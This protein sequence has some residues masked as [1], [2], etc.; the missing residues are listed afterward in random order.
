[1]S[2][3][4]PEFD[5]SDW[6]DP[7]WIVMLPGLSESAARKVLALAEGAGLSF[8]GEIIDPQVALTMSFDRSTA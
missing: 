3:H 4:E 2:K 5:L 6:T 8:G 7:S 1:M